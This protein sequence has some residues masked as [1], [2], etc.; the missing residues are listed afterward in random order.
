LV[1][2][3]KVFVKLQPANHCLEKTL[4]LGRSHSRLYFVLVNLMICLSTLPASAQYSASVEDLD[5]RITLYQPSDKQEREIPQQ[6]IT[7]TAIKRPAAVS[8]LSDLLLSLKIFPDSDAAAL[9]DALNPGSDLRALASLESIRVLRVA[10]RTDAATALSEGYLYRVHYDDHLISWLIHEREPFSKLTSNAS[11]LPLARFADSGL[12]SQTLACISHGQYFFAQIL[13]HLEDRIQPLNHEMLLQLE[14]D[15]KL[16]SQTF[17]RI[18]SSNSLVSPEDSSTLCKI[19]QDL[20]IKQKGFEMTRASD[21]GFLSWPQ[22]KILASTV[23]PAT[24]RL[25]QLWT[26][27]WAAEQLQDDPEQDHQL[28]VLT[29]TAQ[30]QLPEADYVFW[31]TKGASASGRRPVS[32]RVTTDSKP[33]EVQIPVNHE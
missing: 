12:Q 2:I 27:H 11:S 3:E 1:R 26:I 18:G 28:S 6:G 32:V 16:S 29:S 33:L 24:G 20:S 4:R 7:I 5:V 13:D 30:L 25:V 23:D 22:V 21:S 15:I 9:I 19:A 31:A 8:S 17:E 10:P 14:A